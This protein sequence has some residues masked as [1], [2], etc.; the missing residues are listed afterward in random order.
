MM[1]NGGSLNERHNPSQLR[2]RHGV[3][4]VCGYGAVMTARPGDL[5]VISKNAVMLWNAGKIRFRRG[6]AQTPQ[7][8]RALQQIFSFQGKKGSTRKD[9]APDS[10][11]GCVELMHE[12]RIVRKTSGSSIASRKISSTRKGRL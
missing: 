4:G 2:P 9:D 11:C 10:L 6:F 8:A 5:D 3:R 1:V 12:R 7:G